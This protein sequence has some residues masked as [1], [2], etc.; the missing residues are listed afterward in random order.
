MKLRVYVNET[1]LNFNVVKHPKF[2]LEIKL[3][4]FGPWS[5][6][7]CEARNRVPISK[8][9]WLD[10]FPIFLPYSA[11]ENWKMKM[12]PKSPPTSWGLSKGLG[13][14]K[15]NMEPLSTEHLPPHVWGCCRKTWERRTPM[16]LGSLGPPAWR[17]VLLVPLRSSLLH[18]VVTHGPSSNGAYWV[19]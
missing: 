7:V 1:W 11:L 9:H 14:N 4:A 12:A 5:R 3:V 10:T 6:G 2:Y 19:H 17:S 13:S 8:S 15:N 16:F 18:A